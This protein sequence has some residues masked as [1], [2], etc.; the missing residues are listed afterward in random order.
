MGLSQPEGFGEKLA[1]G[2]G[3]SAGLVP[4]PLKLVNEAK[5]L[6]GAAV[7]ITDWLGPTVYPTVPSYAVRSATA[8]LSKTDPVA[9]AAPAT[10]D[11]GIEDAALANTNYAEGGEVTMNP[12]EEL[13]MKYSP[14]APAPHVAR[15]LRATHTAIGHLQNGDQSSAL[16]ALTGSPEAMAH[17]GI[18]QAAQALHGGMQLP[19]AEQDP[20][21]AAQSIAG[22]M[23]RGMASPQQQPM[24]ATAGAA[25]KGAANLPASIAQA[26]KALATRNVPP[27]SLMF[28]AAVPDPE[29]EHL[30]GAYSQ[31]YDDGFRAG[32]APRE[33]LYRKL[34]SMQHRGA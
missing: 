3:E 6:K 17:P 1:T 10:V 7:G 11:P 12:L 2:V 20:S 14:G 27:S 15:A 24:A 28:L 33:A 23:K 22:A 26:T 13:S 34:L 29:I 5:G 16:A 25:M 4:L 18:A 9:A 31:A 32:P 8:A 19:G 21:V 30:M